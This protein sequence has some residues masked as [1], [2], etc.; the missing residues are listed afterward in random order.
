[1]PTIRVAV[2]DAQRYEGELRSAL[3][4]RPRTTARAENGLARGGRVP[5]ITI[6]PL[7]GPDG[8]RGKPLRIVPGSSC[9]H[10]GTLEGNEGY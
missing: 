4:A 2:T 8:P 3:W 7:S 10:L 6:T 9:C 5:F 1:M